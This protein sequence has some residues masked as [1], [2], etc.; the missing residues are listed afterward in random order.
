VPCLSHEKEGIEISYGCWRFG[1]AVER[2]RFGSSLGSLRAAAG[3]KSG[4]RLGNSYVCER[5]CRVWYFGTMRPVVVLFAKQR[6]QVLPEVLRISIQPK[7]TF[8]K[9]GRRGLDCC[10][11]LDILDQN[12]KVAHYPTSELLDF[13]K[14]FFALD[15]KDPATET[16]MAADPSSPAASSSDRCRSPSRRTIPGKRM[17]PGRR[18]L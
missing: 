7:N 9:T 3:R 16:S 18:V 12:Y 13:V 11:A 4:V 8:H 17:P 15:D 2:G 14:H 1:S 6:T 10:L 5:I